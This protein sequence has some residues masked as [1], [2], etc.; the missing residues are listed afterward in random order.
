[1]HTHD[2]R[3]S[4]GA[5]GRLIQPVGRLAYNCDRQVMPGMEAKAALRACTIQRA[6]RERGS[7]THQSPPP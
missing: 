1:M 3:I 6:S 5:A 2:G 4:A 7:V